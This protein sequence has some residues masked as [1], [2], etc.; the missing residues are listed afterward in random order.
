MVWSVYL[1]GK[2][3]SEYHLVQYD[4]GSLNY[5]PKFL[6]FFCDTKLL[7]FRREF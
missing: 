5:A 7:D 3:R 2:E 4:D 6:T 1:W